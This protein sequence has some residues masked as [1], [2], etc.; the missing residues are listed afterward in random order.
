[1]A[2]GLRQANLFIILHSNT[3]GISVRLELPLAKILI[4]ALLT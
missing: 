2:R 1:M 3:N 4:V